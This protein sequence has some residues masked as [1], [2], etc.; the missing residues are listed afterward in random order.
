ME[1]SPCDR[2]CDAIRNRGR[3][4]RRTPGFAPHGHTVRRLPLLDELDPSR[5]RTLAFRPEDLTRSGLRTPQTRISAITESDVPMTSDSPAT[6]RTC[7]TG[8]TAR[9]IHPHSSR[10]AADVEQASRM[11]A[12]EGNCFP[13]RGGPPLPSASVPLGTLPRSSFQPSF[14]NLSTPASLRPQAGVPVVPTPLTGSAPHSPDVPANRQASEEVAHPSS[15]APLDSSEPAVWKSRRTSTP[16]HGSRLAV[17]RH[18]R[19]TPLLE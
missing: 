10:C 9:L 18:Y 12:R 7:G 14:R 11:P 16:S 5:V 3:T 15:R 13:K 6:N 17:R 1:A 2:V 19:P 8:C 4:S